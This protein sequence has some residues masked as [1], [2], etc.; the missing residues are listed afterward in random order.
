[1]PGDL[2]RVIIDPIATPIIGII[3]TQ[4]GESRDIGDFGYPAYR[5][6]VGDRVELHFKDELTPVS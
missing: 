1:M 3:V 4:L 2:V 5:L 6:L